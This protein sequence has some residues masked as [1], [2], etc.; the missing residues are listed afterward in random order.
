MDMQEYH[1]MKTFSRNT[2]PTPVDEPS[3]LYISAFEANYGR[4]GDDL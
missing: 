2:S 4:R 1:E 3:A